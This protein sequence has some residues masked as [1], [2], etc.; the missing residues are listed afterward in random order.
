MTVADA[1]QSCRC[2]AK[3]LFACPSGINTTI[4]NQVT[5]TPGGSPL[6]SLSLSNEDSGGLPPGLSLSLSLSN[7][8]VIRVALKPIALFSSC[9]PG[10][11]I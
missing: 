10:Y 11:R 3:I 4:I 7:E 1:P 8:D 2:S 9:H 6:V 5:K